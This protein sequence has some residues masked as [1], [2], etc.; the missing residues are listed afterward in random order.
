MENYLKMRIA[1]LNLEMERC[2]MDFEKLLIQGKIKELEDCLI[3]L[4]K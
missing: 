2:S 1:K 4:K 3:E